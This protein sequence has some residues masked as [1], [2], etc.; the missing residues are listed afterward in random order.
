MLNIFRGSLIRMDNVEFEKYFVVYS[1]DEI[2]SRYILT[3][4][5]MERILN[6]RENFKKD[7][8]FSFV[9]SKMYLAIPY[10]GPLFEAPLLYGVL[11]SNNVNASFMLIKNILGVVDELNLNMRIWTK[12]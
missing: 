10:S 6:L 5:L 11:D 12:K 7:L 4:L 3:P 9:D 1:D 2:K 8:Y